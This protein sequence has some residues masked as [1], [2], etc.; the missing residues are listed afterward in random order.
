MTPIAEIGNVK[1]RFV[2]FIIE[3]ECCRL[4]KERGVVPHTDDP[5]LAVNR[6]CNVNREHDAVTRW[7]KEHVRDAGFDHR[8]LFLHLLVA[9]I[10]N[11]PPALETV[12]PF[13][14]L[15]AVRAMLQA[16]RMLGHSVF[17][18]AY[19]M[20]VH[21]D[22]GRGKDAIE[23]YCRL[24]QTVDLLY[25]LT[26]PFPS[27]LHAA[28][29]IA[30]VTGLGRFMANQIVTDLRYTEFYDPVRVPDWTSFV[31]AGPG[32]LRGVRRFHGLDPATGKDSHGKIR[33]NA[34]SATD[35][36]LAAREQL[37]DQ[38]P[39]EIARCF[40]DPNNLSNCFCEFDKYERVLG[41]APSGND[42][43]ATLRKYTPMI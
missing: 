10:F 36:V 7:V 37:S 4:K 29:A 21:G 17:R 13:T 40:D 11:H 5:I 30:S 16:R 41:L 9:R 14:D 2:A 31:W 43:K 38:F 23:F 3:R 25:D 19:M 6:F 39:E 12:I 35:A 32:T 20:V 26:V 24:A 8:R 15:D 1:E 33:I 18:G 27:L 28:S 22:E 34:K 42:R